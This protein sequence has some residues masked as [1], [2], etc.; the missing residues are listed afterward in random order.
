M[1]LPVASLSLPP[2]KLQDN[3]QNWWGYLGARNEDV[4]YI[5]FW[6]PFWAWFNPANE[7]V[8]D[9]QVRHT[10]FRKDEQLKTRKT[11]KPQPRK[12]GWYRSRQL[13]MLREAIGREIK[14]QES[15]AERIDRYR[16]TG[17][18]KKEMTGVGSWKEREK[19]NSI[20]I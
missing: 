9:E 12:R 1:Y 15:L 8:G 18:K 4:C 14:S 7:T 2:R 20:D 19:T 16:E 6:I 3:V 10:G 11:T 17:E 5:L 13:A